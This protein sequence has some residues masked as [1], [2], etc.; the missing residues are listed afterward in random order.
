MRS[1]FYH[2]SGTSN[3]L[4]YFFELTVMQAMLT[5]FDP[6]HIINASNLHC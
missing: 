5:N 6:L 3:S 1:I 2:M 4:K